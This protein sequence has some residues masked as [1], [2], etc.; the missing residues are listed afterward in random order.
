M[1][2]LPFL[3]AL[4]PAPSPEPSGGALSPLRTPSSLASSSTD[5]AEQGPLLSDPMGEQVNT[6]EGVTSFWETLQQQ[7]ASSDPSQGQTVSALSHVVGKD[8]PDMAATVDEQQRITDLE[9]TSIVTL[10][11][12]EQ[13]KLT[14]GSELAPWSMSAMQQ[15]IQQTAE[16]KGYVANPAM[17]QIES[18]RIAQAQLQTNQGGV[19]NQ[20]ALQSETH[21]SAALT[22]AIAP[23][24]A[25][26]VPGPVIQGQMAQPAISQ[27]ALANSKEALTSNGLVEESQLGS[28]FKLDE[29]LLSKEP[30]NIHEKPITLV[31]QEAFA[32]NPQGASL[33]QESGLPNMA[34][35]LEGIVGGPQQT[36][37]NLQTAP[38]T[39]RSA[40]ENADKV[41]AGQAKIDVPPSSPKF[42]EQIAQ[43]INIMNG[44]QLQTARI[45]LDPPELG[46]LEIKLKVQQDQVSV[47]F[48]SGNQVVRDA[49]E[50]QAP[51]L[52]EMLEQQGV[53]L[54]DVNVSDQQQAT[55]GEQAD[56]SANGT[57]ED[58]AEDEI[59]EETLVSNIQSDSLVDYYA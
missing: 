3:T 41:L 48:T 20:Y 23:A 14:Q 44:E 18:Q 16:T 50:S 9:E 47:S 7:A 49:L 8:E 25:A 5:H 39:E 55:G 52:K 38:M 24:I 15:A 46:S 19:L 6:E 51:R 30:I 27:F 11:I 33:V 40:T 31:P 26:E 10:Q 13:A 21:L 29:S 1:S 53:E 12:N 32:A 58:G 2:A 37:K 57:G 43:R 35:A 34:D 56:G 17:E 4:P 42:T 54:T 22:P 59:T 36:D 28:G 45:Q